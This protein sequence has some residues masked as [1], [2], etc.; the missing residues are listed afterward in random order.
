MG[1][2][3]GTSILKI[4]SRDHSYLLNLAIALDQF[5]AAIFGYDCDITISAAIGE[6]QWREFGGRDIPCWRNPLKAFIQRELG[7]IQAGH[8]LKAYIRELEKR[9]LEVPPDLLNIAGTHPA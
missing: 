1:K 8:C 5:G 3:A 9:N 6:I 7:D 2:P 4:R